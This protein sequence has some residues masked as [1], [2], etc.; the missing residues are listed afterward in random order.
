MADDILADFTN[1]ASPQEAKVVESKKPSNETTD[2]GYLS[3][4]EERL[5]E[6]ALENSIK[7]STLQNE[8][9]KIVKDKSMANFTAQRRVTMAIGLA[10]KNLQT[11]SNY[12]TYEFVVYGK[13]ILATRDGRVFPKVYGRV[14]YEMIVDDDGNKEERKQDIMLVGIPKSSSDDFYSGIMNALPFYTYDVQLSKSVNP[15]TQEVRFYFTERTEFVNGDAPSGKA[16]KMSEDE[17]Y[18]KLLNIQAVE[19]ISN[20]GYSELDEKGYPIATDMKA[21]KVLI[22]QKN[23]YDVKGHDNLKTLYLRGVDF[24]GQP[25]TIL[26]SNFEDIKM[27]FIE[28]DSSYVS[29]IAIGNLFVGQGG[30]N[31]MSLYSFIPLVNDESED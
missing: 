16:K 13:N 18:N 30:D 21:V 14:K 7:T 27:N 4:A 22:D 26:S 17:L 8:F 20:A 23:Y 10:F 29:G 19:S 1:E 3:L 15:E 6:L 12:P 24:E 5:N 25:I 11:S 31:R 28:N 9:L 2:E